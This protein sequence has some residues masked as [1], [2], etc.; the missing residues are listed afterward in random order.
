MVQT[1]LTIDIYAHTNPA[2]GALVLHE[3]ADSFSK[4]EN[5]DSL[6]TAGPPFPLF[7]IAYPIL[8][9]R[10]GHLSFKA[11]N[12]S[13]GLFEWLARHPELRVDFSLEVKSGKPYVRRSLL[14]AVTYGLLDTDGWYFWPTKKPPWK[15]PPW[16][17]KSD[18][19]GKT[20][21]NARLLGA[22]MGN[23][24]IPTLFQAM[25]VCP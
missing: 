2:F 4:C 24:D 13:T 7:F 3:F 17:A 23:V 20:L 11:C 22:W 1:K 21:S 19:R 25:G 16:K 12:K 14:F 9:T 6:R 18:E 10:K 5:N 8:Y 15:K